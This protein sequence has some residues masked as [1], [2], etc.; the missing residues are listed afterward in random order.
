[1]PNNQL[2][3]GNPAAYVRDVTED[4]TKG[5]LKVRAFS[6]RTIITFKWQFMSEWP[7]LVSELELIYFVDVL[8]FL[9]SALHYA[10]VSKTHSEEFLPFGTAY[11]AAEKN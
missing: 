4:E 7:F 5:I 1:M 6:T 11:Q 8:L 10:D 3:A 2:W 9:Q